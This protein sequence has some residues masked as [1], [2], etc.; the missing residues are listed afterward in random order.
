MH[1]CKAESPKM[2]RNSKTDKNRQ[3]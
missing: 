3:L 2:K 1:A